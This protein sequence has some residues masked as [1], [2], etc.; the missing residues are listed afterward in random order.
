[1]QC[2]HH[3]SASRDHLII[4]RENIVTFIAYEAEHRT[5]DAERGIELVSTGG[6][7]EYKSFL[8]QAPASQL[9]FQGS[10]DS[11]P[12]PGV[13]QFLHAALSKVLIWYVFSVSGHIEGLTTDETRQVITEALTAYKAANG[14]PQGQAVRVI[15][16]MPPSY[17]QHAA[18]NPARN[19]I[20]SFLKA[21]AALRSRCRR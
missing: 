2:P 10:I 13:D 1:M 12:V 4:F 3:V 18:G 11:E 7:P 6:G 15:F 21:V 20:G 9:K 14:Y 5:F 17:F 19:P 16:G 8:L